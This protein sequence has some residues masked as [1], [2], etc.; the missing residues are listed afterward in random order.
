[1]SASRIAD[2][3]QKLV[4]GSLG[5]TTVVAGGWFVASGARILSNANSQKQNSKRDETEK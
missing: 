4:A 1:M 5:V 2:A 3:L